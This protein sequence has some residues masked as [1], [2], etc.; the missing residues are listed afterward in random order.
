MSLTALCVCFGSGIAGAVAWVLMRAA[1]MR[2]RADEAMAPRRLPAVRYVSWPEGREPGDLG[3][4]G[5]DVWS[6]SFPPGS[7][8]VHPES[9][10]YPGPLSGGPRDVED[11]LTGVLRLRHDP[12]PDPR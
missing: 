7:L 6:A 2:D 11:L 12:A 8:G 5:P 4:D 9:A 3:V 10:P 1:D